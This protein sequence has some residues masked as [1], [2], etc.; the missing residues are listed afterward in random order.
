MTDTPAKDLS[1]IHVAAFKASRGWSAGEIAQLLA[2]RHVFIVTCP[3][4]FAIGRVVVDEA[5]LLTIAVT[6]L[7]QGCGTGT[8]LLEDFEHVAA[9][10]G[11]TRAFLEVADDNAPARA[12]YQRAGWSECGR[13]P[14]YY[15]RTTDPACDAILMEK[16]LP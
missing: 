1:D 16:H 9:E 4:G 2:S 10:R 6:P 12:L 14:G 15:A 13:R 11:A 3:D 5:E 7:M 8:K